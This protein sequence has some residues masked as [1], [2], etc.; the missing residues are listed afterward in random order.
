MTII[1]SEVVKGIKDVYS[2]V[3]KSKF[4]SLGAPASVLKS[5]Q[6]RMDS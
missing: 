6:F 5:D 1:D 2:Y 4:C 3:W